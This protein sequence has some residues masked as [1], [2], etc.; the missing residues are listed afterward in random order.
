[1]IQV[2]RAGPFGVEIK[3]HRFLESIAELY[4]ALCLRR[5]GFSGH[6]LEAG[7]FYGTKRKLRNCMRSM[8][9]RGCWIYVVAGRREVWLFTDSLV[10]LQPRQM[11]IRELS[12]LEVLLTAVSRHGRKSAVRKAGRMLAF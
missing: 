9:R 8:R 3:A 5:Y 7:I 6:Q 2:I 4:L 10:I 11:Q 1:M 12:A